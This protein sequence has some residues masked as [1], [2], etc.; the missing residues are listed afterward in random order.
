M[1]HHLPQWLEKKPAR[2]R[3]NLLNCHHAPVTA[4]DLEEPTAKPSP[5]HESKAVT[6]LVPLANCNTD[7]LSPAVEQDPMRL[8]LL[9]AS[10]LSMCHLIISYTLCV[11]CN[12]LSKYMSRK[13]FSSAAIVSLVLLFQHCGAVGGLCY[14]WLGSELCD[15]FRLVM[16][17]GFSSR[18]FK[19]RSRHWSRQFSRLYLSLAGFFSNHWGRWCCMLAFFDAFNQWEK[20]IV[21]DQL[22][23]DGDSWST[24]ST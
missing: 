4:S 13:M 2:L 6:E 15:W 5:H 1:Q 17:T 12:V 23:G 22:T 10:T 20:R 9:W 16:R 21:F 8:L 14:S 7:H 24:T 3:Y 19:V 18:L 11:C